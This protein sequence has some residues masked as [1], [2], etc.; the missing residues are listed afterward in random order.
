MVIRWYDDMMIWYYDDM[1]IW[2]YDDV[3][4][5]WYEMVIDQIQSQ[6]LFFF[7]RISIF[8]FQL[9]GFIFFP[10]DFRFSI[11]GNLKKDFEN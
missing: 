10:F 2:W 9:R 5:W 6:I 1:M 4:I 3:M 8:E 7:L 11:S